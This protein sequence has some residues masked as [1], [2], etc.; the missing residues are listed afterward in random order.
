VNLKV[1]TQRS[2]RKA[3]A[4]RIP[5]RQTRVAVVTVLI[6][7]AALTGILLFA[8]RGDGATPTTVPTT[9]NNGVTP[10]PSGTPDASEPSGRAPTAADALAGY[11]RTYVSDFPGTALPTGWLP[12]TGKPGG[13]PGGQ[14]AATHVTVDGGLLQL[15]TWRDPAFHD[16]WVTGGLCHCGHPQTYGAFFVRTRIT[17]AGPNESHL[18]WPLDNS[19]PP[20]IDFNETGDVTTS[21]SW[22]VHF[23][24]DNSIIQQTL[25]LDMTKWHTWG[26]VWTPKLL[27]FTVDGI[28]WGRVGLGP[29][30]PRI[31]MTLDLQQRTS[32]GY[33]G[34]S[35]SMLVDW[36]TEYAK[37]G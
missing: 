25:Q 23:G 4:D 21:T 3:K 2:E 35:Q 29:A 18:L 34:D 10:Y 30:I 17:G 31:P 22:T 26:V 8:L 14:F 33:S 5:D 19:W 15:N 6:F 16:R 27:T 1:Y 32:A 12:F 7:G 24:R 20:E 13:D 28:A 36:E 9:P 37:R 11:R